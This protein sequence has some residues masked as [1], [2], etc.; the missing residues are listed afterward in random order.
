MTSTTNSTVAILG[1]GSVGITLAQGFASLG[2]QVIFGTRDVASDK[3]RAALQAVPGARAASYAEAAQ[4]GHYAVLAVPLGGLEATIEA[5][6]PGHLAGKLVIDTINALD[7]STGAP[8]WAVGHSDSVGERVQRLL[9]GAKVVKAFNIITVAH[10]VH[11]KLPDGQPDMFI[12][13]NDAS[14]KAQVSAWLGAWGWRT[15]VDMGD[16]AASR[17]LEAL[18]MLWISYGAR[19]NHWTHGFSLLGQK[20]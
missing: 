7:F 19:N 18:A 12:A 14:A 6:G 4:A 8:V 3:T 5:A 1:N 10:M 17:L 11:P 9:P 20:A 13:G 16:I 2:Y 15:P